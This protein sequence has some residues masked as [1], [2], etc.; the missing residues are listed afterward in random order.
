[1][2]RSLIVVLM[3][4]LSGCRDTPSAEHSPGTAVPRAAAVHSDSAAEAICRDLTNSYKC[5]QAIEKS[6]LAAAA[7]S[8]VRAG[9]D[10][11]IALER[12]DSVV[13]TDSLPDDAAGVWFSYRGL[14]PSVGYHLIEVQY[15]EGGRYLLVNRRTGWR[16]SS[17]GVPVISPD[18]ARLAAGNVDLEA[19]YSPTTLQIWSVSVDSLI[20]EFD[21]DFVASPIT[22]DSVWGPR[23][24][25]W[26]DSTELRVEREYSF[27]AKGGMARI[28][29]ENGRW[30]ILAP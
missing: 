9:R 30:R 7:P 14:L 21:H 28:V 3:L 18:S 2:E 19:E 29:R 5:A 24:L 26:R 25:E 11:R 6:L 15:Y 8:V 1:M 16:G 17:N 10:L 27:G 13:F 12:G 20:L 4:V 23:N 22:A